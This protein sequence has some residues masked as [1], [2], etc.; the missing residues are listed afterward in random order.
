[1]SRVFFATAAVGGKASSNGSF[2]PMPE[3]TTH[4]WKLTLRCDAFSG[5]TL[6]ETAATAFVGGRVT[7]HYSGVPD[8]DGMSVSALLYDETGERVG[9]ASVSAETASGTA[10]FT[11]PNDLEP[12]CYHLKVFSELR[13]GD[14]MTDLAGND[15]AVEL[16]VL[17]VP[18]VE[19]ASCPGRCMSWAT[20]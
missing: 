7:L 9:Y 17:P 4:E 12:G 15:V 20:P 6:A 11:L 1:M 10:A 14:C 16:T 8:M 18:S 2:V 5:I 19:G 13:F 3:N